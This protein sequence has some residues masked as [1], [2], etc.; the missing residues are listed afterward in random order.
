MKQNQVIK[1]TTL[2]ALVAVSKS[3]NDMDYVQVIPDNPRVGLV[4]PFS[5]WGKGQLLNNGSFDFIRKK[6]MRGKPELQAGY[7][8]LSF[9]A[10][11]F[12]R[13][14]FTVPSELRAKLPTILRKDSL[15]VINH[16]IKKGFSR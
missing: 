13:V 12:D 3:E 10:D 15:K 4:E 5:G 7:V 11:G 14:T 8:S 9:C 2:S 6:R 16:L 1:T